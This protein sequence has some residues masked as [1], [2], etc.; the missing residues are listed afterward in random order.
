MGLAP[1]RGG[2][3]R[4]AIFEVLGEDGNDCGCV[5][6]DGAKDSTMALTFCAVDIVVGSCG[7]DTWQSC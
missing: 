2:R 6:G 4:G 5:D 1:R 7:L 3:G